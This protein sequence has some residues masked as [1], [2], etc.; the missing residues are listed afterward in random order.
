MSDS[1]SESEEEIE[2][3]SQ[4]NA[5]KE[6]CHKEEEKVEEF[7][8]NEIAENDDG[9]L[10]GKP[11]HEDS[12]EKDF[13]FDDVSPPEDIYKKLSIQVEEPEDL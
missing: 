12:S 4:P 6:E 5:N 2:V 11:S 10:E 3:M 7:D 13:Y 1:E 8:D 9:V